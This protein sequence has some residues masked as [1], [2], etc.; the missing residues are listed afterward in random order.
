MQKGS[1]PHEED[2]D[3]LPWNLDINSQIHFAVQCTWHIFSLVSSSFE[4]F[5]KNIKK[6][7]FL[8]SEAHAYLYIT[9][10]ICI[11]NTRIRKKETN[12]QANKK[13]KKERKKQRKKNKE[14]KKF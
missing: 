5:N 12:K 7:N 4:K 9:W 6:G 14:T 2:Y 3:Q 10:N 13:Q 1:R 8:K 11:D